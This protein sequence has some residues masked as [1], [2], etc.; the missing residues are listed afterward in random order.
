[1]TQREKFF[2]DNLRIAE[3]VSRHVY[4]GIER[5]DLYQ[6][7]AQTLWFSIQKYL[8]AKQQGRKVGPIVQYLYTAVKNRRISYIRSHL[9]KKNSQRVSLEALPESSLPRDYMQ[10]RIEVKHQKVIID[11]RDIL[12]HEPSILKRKVFYHSVVG[13]SYREIAEM[14]ELTENEV[15]RYVHETRKRLRKIHQED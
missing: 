11:G 1:M 6:V 8:E 14:F 13:F 15:R 4:S 10:L 5:Q 7:L 12:R 3:E 2:R 9:A